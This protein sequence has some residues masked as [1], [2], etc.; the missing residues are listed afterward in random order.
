MNRIRKAVKR[1][2]VTVVLVLIILLI[3]AGGVLAAAM[4][5]RAHLDE[6]FA[7]VPVLD[8]VD[9]L[10]QGQAIFQF[11]DDGTIYYKLN[12]ANIENIFMAHIHLIPA[13]G[14][15]GLGAIVVWLY[16]RSCPPP[17]PT[18]PL[19]L[20]GRTDGVLAEGVIT[21][22]DLQSASGIT[23]GE[24]L[25]QA[26]AE[27]KVYVNVHTNDFVA[28]PNT[29]PGDYPAGEIHGPIH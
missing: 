24:Q 19:Y 25:R 28:P 4:N 16:P 9:S 10:A 15:S 3:T 26:M 1:I 2:P 17:G 5:F 20:K 23:T 21:D 11:N 7:A 12:V 14:Q 13:P 22:A 8:N 18:S 6:S 27:G 29:G